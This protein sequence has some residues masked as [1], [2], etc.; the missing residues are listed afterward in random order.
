M[1]VVVTDVACVER[2]G[3]DGVGRSLLGIVVGSW[4]CKWLSS[5]NKR[6]ISDFQPLSH[7]LILQRTALPPR[8]HWQQRLPVRHYDVP[9][10]LYAVL[11]W[12]STLFD[13][14]RDCR[15][16]TCHS[17]PATL[18]LGQAEK[19]EKAKCFARAISSFS[20]YH[21]RTTSPSTTASKRAMKR[22]G[23][24]YYNQVVLWRL[25]DAETFT[26]NVASWV[27]SSI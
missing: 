6:S 26:C 18:I 12:S 9:A 8:S 13:Q 20:A 10:L 17:V 22:V 4:T 27:R 15:E 14:G 24:L 19:S 5:V 21:R 1:A 11:N 25:Q 2:G 16:F 7:A 23:A 3:R